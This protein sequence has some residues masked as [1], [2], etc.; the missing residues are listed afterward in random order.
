MAR[1]GRRSRSKQRS[2][3]AG[4]RSSKAKSSKKSKNTRGSGAKG[5]NKGKSKSTSSRSK[6]TSK[7]KAPSKRRTVRGRS[8]AKTGGGQKTNPTKKA[9]PKKVAVKKVVAKKPAPKKPA[10]KKDTKVA[11]YYGGP[12]AENLRRIKA[13]LKEMERR[14]PTKGG[15]GWKGFK[16]SPNVP[17]ASAGNVTN[18]GVGQ[19]KTFFKVNPASSYGYPSQ[20]EVDNA[21]L[22]GGAGFI[23]RKPTGNPNVMSADGTFNRPGPGGPEPESDYTSYKPG[24]FYNLSDTNMNLTNALRSTRNLITSPARA[25]GINTGL[26]NKLIPKSN[27]AIQDARDQRGPRPTLKRRGGGGGSSRIQQQAAAAELLPETAPQIGTDD[28]Q[29]ATGGPVQGDYS[30]SPEEN[31]S[32]IQN[33]AYNT[34]LTSSLAGMFGGQGSV[35]YTPQGDQ[36]LSPTLRAGRSRGRRRVRLF[37]ARRRRGGTGDQFSRAG[38]RIAKLTNINI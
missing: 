10:P 15:E 12:K 5:G 13:D 7:K 4:S 28:R 38:D 30:V 20:A 18:L 14:D 24:S 25:L 23:G 19:E 22:S 26:T 36:A 11:A 21:A 35:G 16:F 6:S 8:G 34:Q 37:G 17:L 9:A 27:E 32:R 1:R 33:Q 2:K 29:T 3:G 31:L